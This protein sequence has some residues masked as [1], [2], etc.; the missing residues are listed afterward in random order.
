[1]THGNTAS[2]PPQAPQDKFLRGQFKSRYQALRRAG[3]ELL[4]SGELSPL[5]EKDVEA[6]LHVCGTLTDLL[7]NV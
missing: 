3:L 6:T 5:E 4:S 2:P 1:M 7:T